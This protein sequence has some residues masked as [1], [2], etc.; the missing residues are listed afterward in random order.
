MRCLLMEGH[1]SPGGLVK[2]SFLNPNGSQDLTIGKEMQGT[3]QQEKH[4]ELVSGSPLR[5]TQAKTPDIECKCWLYLRLATWLP[6][7]P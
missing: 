5:G 1:M 4:H 7:P 6:L 3:E 2:K